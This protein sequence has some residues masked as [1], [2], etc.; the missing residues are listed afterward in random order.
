MSNY[1]I[2]RYIYSTNVRSFNIKRKAIESLIIMAWHLA[3]ACTLHRVAGLFF[4]LTRPRLSADQSR[5][6][7]DLFRPQAKAQ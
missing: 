4:A 2:N 3:P 7:T 6:I 1:H 5:M